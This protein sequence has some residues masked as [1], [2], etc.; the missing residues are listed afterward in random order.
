MDSR[1]ISNRTAAFVSTATSPK[2]ALW[3][4]QFGLVAEIF[5]ICYFQPHHP[6]VFT[7]DTTYYC[8]QCYCQTSENDLEDYRAAGFIK[9]SSVRYIRKWDPQRTLYQAD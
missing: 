5:I 8:F 4:G 2:V 6:A 9:C 3:C 1:Y 7:H